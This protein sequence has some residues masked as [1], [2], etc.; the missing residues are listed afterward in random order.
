METS[1][2][3][4]GTVRLMRDL[5]AVELLVERRPGARTRLRRELGASAEGLIASI[6]HSLLI[7]QGRRATG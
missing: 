4:R 7:S 6:A 5:D 2:R 3:R 1:I